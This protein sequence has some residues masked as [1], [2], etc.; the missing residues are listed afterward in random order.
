MGG[1]LSPVLA[2]IFMEHLEETSLN[3]C[4]VAPLLYKHYVDDIILIWDLAKGAYMVL[5][6]IMNAQNPNIN[7]MVEEENHGV[8]PFLDLNITCPDPRMGRIL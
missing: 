2:R 1:R 6:E 7:L 5:L 8:L 3:L 4:P